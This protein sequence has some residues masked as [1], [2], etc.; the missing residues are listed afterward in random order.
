MRDDVDG[1][2][3]GHGLTRA[4]IEWW[5][6]HPGGPKVLEALE[7]A[8]E[9]PRRAVEMT[10][11]SLARIGNLSSVSVL[12]VLQDTLRDRPPRPG[13]WGLVTA[14]GPGFCSELVLVRAGGS[15]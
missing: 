13:S 12:H 15:A 7:E 14:M 8:L 6:C 1:F 3:A 4:D 9:V 5:V 2:L 11:D 10:W